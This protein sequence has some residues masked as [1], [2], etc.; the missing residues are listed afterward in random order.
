MNY[1][2]IPEHMREGMRR[3]LEEGIEPGSFLRAVLENNFVQACAQADSINSAWLFKWAEFLWW[4]MPGG[5]WGSP[6][7]VQAW[8]KSRQEKPAALPDKENRDDQR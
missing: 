3:Y 5:S 1:E 8:M 4:E 6:E 2:L 7:K